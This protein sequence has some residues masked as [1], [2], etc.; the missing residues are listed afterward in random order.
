MAGAG[1]KH[2]HFLLPTHPIS[3]SSLAAACWFSLSQLLLRLSLSPFS[4]SLTQMKMLPGFHCT[5]QK[6]LFPA[7]CDG[8]SADGEVQR[9]VGRL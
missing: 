1:R 3:I 5:S 6:E 2:G 8:I 7:A 4:P 9:P